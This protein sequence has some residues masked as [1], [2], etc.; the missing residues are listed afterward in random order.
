MTRCSDNHLYL[1]DNNFKLIKKQKLASKN[2]ARSVRFSPDGSRIVVGFAGSTK[3]SVHSGKDLS[4]LYDPTIKGLSATDLQDVCWSTDGKSLFAAGYSTSDKSKAVLVRWSQQGRGNHTVYEAG[5]K[6][7]RDIS[8]TTGGIVFSGNFGWGML[9]YNGNMAILKQSAI[10]DY[11]ENLKNFLVATDGS[12][13]QFAFER[14]GKSPA[15][16]SIT[17]RKLTLAP[18]KKT[19]LL[20]PRQSTDEMRVTNW[21]LKEKPTLNGKKLTLHGSD[22]ARCIAVDPRRNYLVVGAC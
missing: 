10:A 9:S 18:A 14:E 15:L 20:P 4:N 3:V 6:L 1:Y 7:I 22:Q 13:V 8:A 17:E 19:G 12:A 2:K 21:W 16:F 11:Q 5:R